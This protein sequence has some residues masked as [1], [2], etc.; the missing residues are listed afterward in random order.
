M[1][2][3]LKYL[4]ALFLAFGLMVNDGT[5]ETKSN[6]VEYY[7][8]SNAIVSSEWKTSRSKLYVYNQA[9]AVKIAISIP[10]TYLQF[11][12][13]YS[14]QIK[15]LVKLRTQLYQKVSSFTLQHL[16]LNEIT[17]STKSLNSLY[18]A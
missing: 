7:Q 4:I 16:F 8:F 11:A 3:Q 6:Q 14:L 9:T 15:V 2:K 13:I 1:I 10:F 17:I 18:I 12:A 5:L